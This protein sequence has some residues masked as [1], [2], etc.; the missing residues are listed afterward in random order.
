MGINGI[1]GMP[2]MPGAGMPAIDDIAFA[3]MALR[4]QTLDG[5]IADSIKAQQA[6]IDLGNAIRTR[7][8]QLARELATD[9]STEAK[10]PVTVEDRNRYNYHIDE[11]G[12]V[13]AVAD[14]KMPRTDADDSHVTQVRHVEAEIERLDG[15]LDNVNGDSEIAMMHLNRLVN[16]R[17]TAL[18]MTTN[19]LSSMHQSQ[20]GII[21]NIGK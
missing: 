7:R 5:E 19:V 11:N 14:G 1:S 6:K 17:Q 18:Q 21:N 2:A 13:V 9:G 20:M 4:L 10:K 16:Q 8:D 15:L 12:E 3:V